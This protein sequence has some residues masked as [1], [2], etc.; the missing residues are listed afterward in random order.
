M[1][2]GQNM[3]SASSLRSHAIFFVIVVAIIEGAIIRSR[4]A[5]RLDSF[6]FDAASRGGKTVLKQFHDHFLSY[7]GLPIPVVRKAMMEADD[8]GSLF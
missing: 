2:S 7:C 6:T 1:Y 5:T 3:S 4:I 8:K